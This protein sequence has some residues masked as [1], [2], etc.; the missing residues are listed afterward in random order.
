MSTNNSEVEAGGR[1]D[2]LVMEEASSWRGLSTQNHLG[3]VFSNPDVSS[4]I[5]QGARAAGRTHLMNTLVNFYGNQD[6]INQ[7]EYE[8]TVQT[9]NSTQGTGLAWRAGNLFDAKTGELWIDQDLKRQ[10]MTLK[11][12]KDGR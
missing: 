6:Q 8:W 4:M 2:V 1:P 9:T 10:I 11:R 5:V 7:R 12:G 3:A